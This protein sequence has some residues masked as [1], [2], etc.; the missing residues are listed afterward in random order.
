MVLSSL[1]NYLCITK[2]YLSRDSVTM[3]S[4]EN[5]N[6]SLRSEVKTVVLINMTDFILD[7]SIAVSTQLYGS[8]LDMA[9]LNCRFAGILILGHRQTLFNPVLSRLLC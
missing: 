2:V 6:Y 7:F 8:D 3:F 4:D 1:E 5:Y 9:G